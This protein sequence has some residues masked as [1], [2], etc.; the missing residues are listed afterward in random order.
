MKINKFKNLRSSRG[1]TIVELL[2]VIIV[3]AILA[4]LVITAYNGV[5]AKARDV[6][7]QSDAESVQKAAEAYNADNGSYPTSAA[8]FTASGNTVKLDSGIHLTAASDPAVEANTDSDGTGT[9]DHEAIAIKYCGSG[10]GITA[11]YWQ[12]Q[13]SGAL[14]NYVAGSC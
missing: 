9:N 12:E 14:K 10:A 5:Q 1:F 7:R 6:K 2:I 3:I 4:T 11:Y 13:G 8:N